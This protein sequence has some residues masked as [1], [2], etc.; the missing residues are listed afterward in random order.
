[1]NDPPSTIA[2]PLDRL[3]WMLGRADDGRDDCRSAVG[4]VLVEFGAAVRTAATGEP[5][6]G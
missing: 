1:M 6:D 5:Q 2:E 4:R 3:R